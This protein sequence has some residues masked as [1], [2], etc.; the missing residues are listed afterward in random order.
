[1]GQFQAHTLEQHT[2]AFTQY[3]PSDKVF[4]AK[5]FDGSNLRKLFK[6]LSGELVRVDQIFQSVWDGTNLLET[7]DPDYMAAWE[8]AVGIPN[9]YFTQTTSLTM[10]QRRNQVLIQL[11]SLGVLTAQDF[12]DLAA[13]LGITITIS[14]GTEISGFPL[15]F[16]FVFFASTTAARFT[17][18]VNAPVSLSPY[19]F[20]M[21]FPLTFSS[22][23]SNILETL[24][25]ILKPANTQ[26]IF[27]YNLQRSPPYV[28]CIKDK[29]R[30][31]KCHRI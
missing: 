3:L 29:R 13:L 17:M 12:I 21:T 19:S 25:N 6:G 10:D 31:F 20:P 2:Q 30:Y 23:E 15:V 24:F 9:S 16:P 8:S 22:D 18:V 7:N 28:N 4:A 1:M 14:P 27:N 11:R 26:I 5:N